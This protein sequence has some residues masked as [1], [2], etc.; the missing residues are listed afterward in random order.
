[1]ERSLL[2]RSPSGHLRSTH[3]PPLRLDLGGES[4]EVVA[5]K[6]RQ[7]MGDAA[8]RRPPQTREDAMSDIAEEIERRTS[9]GYSYMGDLGRY[10]VQHREAILEAL[11]RPAPVPADVRE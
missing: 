11:R 7:A 5:D 3:I 9:Q 2:G 8:G 10:V 1:M 4:A 6:V